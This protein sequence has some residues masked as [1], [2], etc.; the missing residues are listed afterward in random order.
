MFKYKF[1]YYSIQFILV[2]PKPTSTF[3]LSPP[4]SPN[5]LF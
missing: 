4:V 1:N 5:Y 2:D 3:D